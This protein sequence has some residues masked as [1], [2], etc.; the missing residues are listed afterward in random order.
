MLGAFATPDVPTEALGVAV[1]GGVEGGGVVGGGVVGG[2]VVGGGVVVGG[3]VVGGVA[4]GGVVVG[5]VA[6][7]GVA[8]GGL[9]DDADAALVPITGLARTNSPRLAPAAPVD[10]DWRQPVTVT[11]CWPLEALA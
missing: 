9:A 5:G 4:E 8:D 6:E 7:G 10:P 3:V 2:G 1:G 11:A